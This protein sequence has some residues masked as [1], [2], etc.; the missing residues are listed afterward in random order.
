MSTDQLRHV[1]RFN[2]SITQRLGALDASF[3]G[4]GRPLSEARVIYEIGRQREQGVEVRSLREALALDSGYMS[5][6]LRS[7]ERQGLVEMRGGTGDARVRRAVLTRKGR[8]ER[9][10][11]D[12]LSDAF[13]ETVLAP[14]SAPQRDR[15]VA[16]ME[17]VER[18][19][20][21]F[22]VEVRA[23]PAAGADA[24]WCLE[25]YFRELAAR[26]D[27]GF[28][29]AVTLSAGIPE[30]TPPAGCFFIAR[31]D[32]RPVGCG[33]LRV[34]SRRIGE[35]KRMWVSD[36]ARGLGVGRRLLGAVEGRALAIGLTTLRLDTNRA[37]T[38][39]Q[40][41]YRK[42]GYREVR[43]FNDEP[44]AHHWFAKRLKARG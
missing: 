5:R 39:A 12:R 13:A 4:R 42:S 22:A 35:V 32:G 33:A 18:L 38:E 3:L 36:F 34:K 6:L 29:H 20:G 14:L 24:H 25:E 26:F 10:A 15:L 27:G 44:Y 16:A 21:A 2:R 19:T 1:R 11:Y 43:P 37:L 17:Q 40:A 31:L 8:R 41:L 9:D 7:L 28:D 23:E 30:L